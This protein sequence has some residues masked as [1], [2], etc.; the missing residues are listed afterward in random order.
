MRITLNRNQDMLGTAPEAALTEAAGAL[1]RVAETRPGR[2]GRRASVVA[3]VLNSIAETARGG[4]GAEFMRRRAGIEVERLSSGAERVMLRR[5]LCV[6]FD[7]ARVAGWLNDYAAGLEDARRLDEAAT[8]IELARA[9]EPKRAEFALRA[10]RIARL[11][12]NPER[13]LALYRLASR[14]D[15]RGG[16]IARLAAVGEATVAAD[17]ERA[18]AVAI[19]ESIRTG[20]QEAAAVGLEERARTR[21][22]KGDRDGAARD[23]AIAAARYPD[24]VDRARAAHQLADLFIAANDPAAAR[25]AL[26]FAL[27]S[28]DSTQRDHARGRLHTIAR[29]LGDQLAMRRWRSSRPPALVSLSAK[30]RGPTNE[31]RLTD[32][33][34][35]RDR[36]LRRES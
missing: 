15:G 13:A 14:L 11:G 21:R 34:R 36:L 7:A 18:L 33:I 25:E 20:D 31:S 22:A 30:V 5:L 3:L 24:A 29:D 10:G 6:E 35:W 4:A 16:A 26:L 2:R 17:A 12:G 19:R 1:R 32:V 27:E 23:L 28:G 9:L 8:V